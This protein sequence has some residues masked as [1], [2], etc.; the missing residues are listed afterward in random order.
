[1]SEQRLRTQVVT[2][3]NALSFPCH[4]KPERVVGFRL[5][6]GKLALSGRIDE[7]VDAITTN[8]QHT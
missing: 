3:P 8:I 1:M 6:I 4:I 2:D 5:T 7:M